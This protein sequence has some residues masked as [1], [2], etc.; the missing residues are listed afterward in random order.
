MHA[1][2]IAGSKPGFEPPYP[3]PGPTP[4]NNLIWLR[5]LAVL[6]GL[7]SNPITTFSEQAFEELVTY[8]QLFNQQIALV[9]D[10][11]FLR[12]I[13]IDNADALV[14]D[15]VRQSVLKPALRE[16]MLTA[17]GESWRKAR[18]TISPVFAPRHVNGF[19]NGMRKTTL[20]FIEETKISPEQQNIADQMTRLAYQVLSH[21]LFSGDL[22]EDSEKVIGDVA[23]FLKHLSQP[24]PIDF[25]NAPEWVPRLTKLRGTQALK[26]L[27]HAVRNTAKNR[28]DR[29][30]AGEEL[31]Q[32][33]LTLL[34]TAGD[35]EEQRLSLDEI[36]DNIITFIAAGHETTARALAWTLYLLSF[37]PL[38]RQKCEDEVDTLDRNAIPPQDWGQHLPWVTACF[39]ESMRLFPPAAIIARRANRDIQFKDW[40]IK[41]GTNI[42]TSPWVLHRHKKIWARPNEFHPERFFADNRKSIRRF[43]YLPFGLGHRVCIGAS[44]AM[45]EAVII[46]TEL[47]HAFRFDY[48]GEKKPW[49]VM[50]ITIQPDNGMPM[51]RTPRH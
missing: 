32:D 15:P 22:D 9:H 11:E 36:E 48:S 35:S 46:L 31:P 17:E 51:K 27:R 19:A 41:S 20:Q 29:M 38:A 47:L 30:K 43:D 39:E 23:Y 37:D 13:F 44:F 40:T 50:R 28:S 16:G 5:S 3:V 49:P 7:M 45:Q 6:P 10:S 12:H 21:T 26:R 14:A 34:L 1:D 24:D 2:V 18:R 42:L 4:E 8:T 25:L 33:F